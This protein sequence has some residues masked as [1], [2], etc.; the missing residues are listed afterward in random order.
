MLTESI[1]EKLIAI[2]RSIGTVEGLSIRSSLMEVES[3]VLLIEQE[4]L[5]LLLEIRNLREQCDTL[6]RSPLCGICPVCSS[7]AG[8]VSPPAQA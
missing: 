2:E 7:G 1:M 3:Q 8:F 4:H 6:P 5:N